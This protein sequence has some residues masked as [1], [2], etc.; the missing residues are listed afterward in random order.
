MK[1]TIAIMVMMFL[2]AMTIQA[3]DK[4]AALMIQLFL[5]PQLTITE[6]LFRLVMVVVFLL[7]RIKEKLR[8]C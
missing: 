7:S 4:P 1:K 2:A 5:Q 3:Q 6:L 8:L